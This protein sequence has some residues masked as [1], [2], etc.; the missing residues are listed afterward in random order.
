MQFETTPT[1]IMPEHRAELSDWE[2]E[3]PHK[4]RAEH[5]DLTREEFDVSP[6]MWDGPD[7]THETVHAPD[8]RQIEAQPSVIEQHNAM[9][10]EQNVAYIGALTPHIARMRNE[11]VLA[12]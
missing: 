12:A 3:N 7:F 1:F 2:I 8:A 6:P 11:F 5:F 4:S 9:T 10:D